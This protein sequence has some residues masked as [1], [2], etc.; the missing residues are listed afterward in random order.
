[1][2]ADDVASSVLLELF[3]QMA[4]KPAFHEL[5]TCQRLGYSVHL[6]STALQRQLALE[7]R[8]QSPA[9]PPRAIAAAVRAWLGGFRAELAALATGDKLDSYKQVCVC[10]C[11]GVCCGV[12]GV[13]DVC[14]PAQLS[15]LK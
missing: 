11:C 1:V 4:A 8:V 5:R 3:V 12:C 7:L 10:V 14:A 6:A 2:G 9:A 15:V 13:R